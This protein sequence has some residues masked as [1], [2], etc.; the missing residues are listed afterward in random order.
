MSCIYLGDGEEIVIDVDSLP[1]VNLTAFPG[2]KELDKAVPD[3]TSEPI[4]IPDGLIFGDDI[5]T[6]TYV[7]PYHFIVSSQ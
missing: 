1:F 5:V 4:Y 7:G 6:S 3:A 2:V